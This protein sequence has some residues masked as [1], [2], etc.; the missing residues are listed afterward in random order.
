[1]D[2]PNDMMEVIRK[3]GQENVW[4]D[5]NSTWTAI[6][7]IA[8]IFLQEENLRAWAANYSIVD[9]PTKKVGLVMAGNIP[10]VGLHDLICCLLAGHTAIVKLSSDDKVLLP[11]VIKNLA[12][13][14][15][16]INKLVQFV[17]RLVDVSF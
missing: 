3:A 5:S 9:R 6:E 12:E 1:M 7:N 2:K 16:E 13:S 11:L 15:P 4:F 10:L 8:T 17:E 14:H